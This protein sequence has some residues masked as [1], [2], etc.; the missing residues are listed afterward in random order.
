MVIVCP[1]ILRLTLTFEFFQPGKEI[2]RF[3]IGERFLVLDRAAM[4]HLAHRKL[5]DLAGFRAGISATAMILAGT[6]RGEAPVRMRVFIALTRSS[7]RE[8]P[9]A[10]RTKSTTRTSSSQS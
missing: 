4:H 10:R 3:R 7:V 2:Q 5:H 8:T 9:A 6:W 1:S